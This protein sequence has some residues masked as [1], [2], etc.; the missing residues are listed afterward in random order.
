MSERNRWVEVCEVEDVP[1]LEGRRVVVNG[2]YVAVF[3]TEEGFFAVG[4]VCPHMGGRSRTG[5]WPPRPFRAR[6]TR[7]R[8]R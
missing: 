1:E 5:T 4:D 8:S 3:N 6:R 7:A 2:F